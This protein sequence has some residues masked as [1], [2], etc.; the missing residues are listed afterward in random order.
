L[1]RVAGL[2]RDA[3]FLQRHDSR[4]SNGRDAP[5]M[6]E[7]DFNAR[8]ERQVLPWLDDAYHL[9]LWLLQND[10]DARDAVQEACLR[11]FRFFAGCH[12]ESSKRWLLE[13]VHNVCL[14]ALAKRTQERKV[15]PLNEQS[16]EVPDPAPTPLAELIRKSTLEAVRLALENL[17]L[18]F[19]SV[20]VWR[21]MEGL[22]YKEIAQRTGLPLG[23]VMSRLARARRQLRRVLT[24]QNA[25][26]QL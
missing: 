12:A 1:H 11:A 18:E 19:R 9:A 20:L 26:G 8:F 22:S 5:G 7:P 13:I 21:E 16:F 10:Q 15:I 17:P 25:W 3:G 2:V 24:Q 6:S 23:T 14:D 4:P